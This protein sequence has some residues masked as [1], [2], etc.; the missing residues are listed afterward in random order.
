MEPLKNVDTLLFD[1][2]G[3]LTNLWTRYRDPFYRA[4]NKIKPDHDKKR[5]HEVFEKTV[6]D[7]LKTFE[8]NKILITLK[9]FRK[10]RK[11]MGGSLIDTFRVMK[12]VLSDPMAFRD[13]EPLEGV[14]S[15][16]E[17]LQERGYRL[18]LVTNA[19]DKTV[20]IAK[21]KLKILKSFDILVTRNTVKRIK[22]H[23]D[24]LLYVCEQLG[25]DPRMCAMIGD[26]P[27][28]VKAGKAA[29]T[30]TIAILGENGKYTEEEI[31]LLNPDVVL[32]S[33]QELTRL[34]PKIKN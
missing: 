28:D 5:L 24:A 10:S 8:G 29:G 9:L 26:F 22:P 7:F 1:M 31:R 15:T 20:S 25:K 30:K 18:A 2:D 19:G 6:A 21:E 12:I 11:E 16:L 14:D 34:F 32:E 17:I 4:L 23:P 33:F 3:T 13:I 27:Q